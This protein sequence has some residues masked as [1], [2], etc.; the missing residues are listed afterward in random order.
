MKTETKTVYIADD[1]T[2]FADENECKKYENSAALAY[3]TMLEGVLTSI[4][5]SF[6]SD[7]PDFNLFKRVI[8]DVFDDGRE[9]CNYFIFKPRKGDDVKNFIA[10]LKAENANIRGYKDEQYKNFPDPFTQL[11]QLKCGYDYIVINYAESS[12][13][14]IIEAEQFSNNIKE[15]IEKAIENV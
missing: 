12:F 15:I 7:S 1:G 2:K 9:E 14:H 11:N 10:M 6:R 13:Y 3:K 4:N 8:D 5:G